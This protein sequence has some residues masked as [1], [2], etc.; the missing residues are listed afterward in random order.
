M[1]NSEKILPTITVFGKDTK[2]FFEFSKLN[3]IFGYAGSGKS[4]FLSLLSSIFTGKDRHHLVNG[5]QTVSKD[6]N[7]IY[8]GGDDGISN[9][10]KLN[11]KSLL[12]RII[13]ESKYSE[14]FDEYCDQM[15]RGMNH[16]QEEIEARIKDVLPGS[17]IRMN[18]TGQPLDF[19]IDNMTI[20]IEGDSSSEEK[21]KLFGLINS[22]SKNTTIKTIVL[23][24]DFSDDFDEE[25]TLN[26]LNEIDKSNA[27]FFLTTKRAVPQCYL[28]EGAKLFAVREFET[29]PL[30]DIKTLLL[31]SLVESREYRTFEEYITGNGYIENS[32]LAEM[33]LH[34][35]QDDE[36]NNLLRILTAK[37][38]VLAHESL[39]GKV[40]IIPIN[41]EEE[42]LYRSV[43]EILG[44]PLDEN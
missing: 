12:R 8:L 29:I 11:S 28:R 23:I 21:K 4:T 16:A 2:K 22:L 43:F 9:H 5:T 27:Y 13:S 39:P 32:G 31:H 40:T 25:T 15:F 1:K 14:S 19:L 3:L 20:E 37:S 30:P 35:V 6:F 41:P 42:K 33:F 10:L 38:P 18:D 7:V 36:K 24:D 44:I 17:T 34:Y 26:F